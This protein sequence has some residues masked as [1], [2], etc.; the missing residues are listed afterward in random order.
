M[1]LSLCMRVSVCDDH[2]TP[3]AEEG[4]R[5]FH[6]LE[7]LRTFC[8]DLSAVLVLLPSEADFIW[9]NFLNNGHA[10]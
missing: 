6:L 9:L 8:F 10:T 7:Y 1:T 2:C 3:L 4:N 5:L